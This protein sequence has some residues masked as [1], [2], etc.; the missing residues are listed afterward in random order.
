MNLMMTRSHSSLRF[1]TA[2]IVVLFLWTPLFEQQAFAQQAPVEVVE[3]D[4]A[5]TTV[6]ISLDAFLHTVHGTFRVKRGNIT[7]APAILAPATGNPATAKAGGLIVVD[8][9]SGNT[10]NDGRDKTMHR[11]VLESDKFPEVT[12]TPVEMDGRLA[13]EGDS[14]VAVRGVL[15]LH[16]QNHDV[17]VQAK[18]HITQGQWTAHAEFTVPYVAWGLKNPSNLVLHVKDT[19]QVQVH[20]AGRIRPPGPNAN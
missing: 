3:L 13:P 1:L 17:T 4:P 7:L 9:T 6:E 15:N 18:V 11:K 2:A 19:V 8:A 10:A 16:G 12:F 5:R 20:A 14:Q